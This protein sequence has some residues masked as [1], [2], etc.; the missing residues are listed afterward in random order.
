MQFIYR[1]LTVE[2]IH[3]AFKRRFPDEELSLAFGSDSD[4]DTGRQAGVEFMEKSGLKKTPKVLLNGVALDDSGLSP[5]KIE[6][7]IINGIMKATP[8]LQRYKRV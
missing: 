5:D 1:S 8:K 7:T 6:E 3:N 4:Y 2:E